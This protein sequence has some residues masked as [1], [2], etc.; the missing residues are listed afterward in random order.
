M[1]LLV[2]WILFGVVTA[3]VAS[4]KGLN[5]CGWFA[6]GTFLGPFGLIL[7]LVS[8]ENRPAVEAAAVEGGKMKRCPFC[9]EMIRA[10]A[11][12]C[13]YCGEKLSVAPPQAALE[14]TDTWNL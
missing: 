1:E 6:L 10:E 3:V 4:N 7:A 11:I 12:K 9:A 5:G 8:N 13:R 14:D 2:I